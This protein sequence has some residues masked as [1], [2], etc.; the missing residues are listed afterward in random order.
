MKKSKIFLAA[1]ALVT[2]QTFLNSCNQDS[3]DMQAETSFSK[4]SDMVV[5]K[6]NGDNYF[7]NPAIFNNGVAF[8]N[9]KVAQHGPGYM[10]TQT[11]LNE[12][13]QIVQI[14]DAD[15]PSLD[16]VNE[17]ITQTTALSSLPFY[18]ALN[19][20]GYSDQAKD[21]AVSITNSYMAD[22]ETKQTFINLP[23]NEKDFLKNLNQYRFNFEQ[24]AIVGGGV[25]S[26]DGGGFIGGA[27]GL[28]VGFALLGPPGAFVGGIVGWFVGRALDK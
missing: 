6:F 14:P 2:S 8:V 24:G 10:L 22:L 28:G 21:L 9:A 4:N 23:Q 25:M 1:V 26:K 3:A 13:Y 15:R 5:N 7:Q 17:L 16:M 27:I 18:E 11:D 19:T 12:F 20:L